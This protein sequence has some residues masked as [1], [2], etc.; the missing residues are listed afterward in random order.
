MVLPAPVQTS[1][2]V[3]VLTCAT[4]GPPVAEAVMARVTGSPAL[5]VPPV[6]GLEQRIS[7]WAIE[8]IDARQVAVA[9]RL[10]IHDAGARIFFLLRWL[11]L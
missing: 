3:R 4:K 8:A 7:A 10:F 6:L 11:L 1:V 2:A 5:K 9:R